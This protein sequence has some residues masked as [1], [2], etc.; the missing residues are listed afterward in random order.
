MINSYV[1]STWNCGCGALNAGYR[2][3]CGACGKPK[4]TPKII[5]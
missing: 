4:P 3:T 5:H 2:E 1:D